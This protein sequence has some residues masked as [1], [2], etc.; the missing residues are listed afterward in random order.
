[1]PLK[2]RWISEFHGPSPYALSS[3]VVARI[4][5]DESTKLDVINIAKTVGE[6]FPEW[7]N[8]LDAWIL[9][10]Q[11]YPASQ[12]LAEI[13]VHCAF[14]LLNELR[15]CLHDRGTIEQ[16]NDVLV[17][18]GFHDP[19]ISREALNWAFRCTQYM[20]SQPSTSKELHDQR[21][22]IS[23]TCKRVH[24]DYQAQILMQ[25]A[26][27]MDMP[28]LRYLNGTK[29]WQFGW[30][31]RSE[32]F[33]ESSSTRD[34]MAGYMWS[35]NKISSKAVMRA[36]GLPI[37]LHQKVSHEKELLEAVSKISYPCVIKPLTL[38]GGKGVTANIR[39]EQELL[40][41]Y[42]I[43][44][45]FTNDALM[46]ERHIEGADHRLLMIDGKL[47]AAIR[48][49]PS[50]VVGNGALTI[51]ELIDK[52]NQGRSN[53]M[54]KSGYLRPISVDH[55][56]RQQLISQGVELT[57]V[58]EQGRSIRLR[59]NA[60]LSTGG[61]CTDVTALVHPQVKWMAEQLAASLGV[62]ILGIDY[63]SLN[64]SQSPQETGGAFIETNL[65]PGLDACV[66]A[67]WSE[68]EIGR[69]VL[70]DQLG[71]IDV[72]LKVV[73]AVENFD[74]K[75]L[76]HACPNP[77]TPDEAWVCCDIYRYGEVSLKDPQDGPWSAVRAALKNKKIKRLH[78]VCRS[79]DI[80]RDG[81]PVDRFAHADLTQ[82]NLPPSW[83]QL[84][85]NLTCGEQAGLEICI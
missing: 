33:I 37:A 16:E 45:S 27:T 63:L 61:L 59:S 66:A 43:A 57:D 42:V 23:L 50:C 78:I 5:V 17:W 82:A 12:A 52:L 26:K 14:S 28:F 6:N 31:N 8:D 19:I 9:D 10:L 75:V 35:R 73:D 80:L 64:I 70:G 69:L 2:L 21:Q 44:R 56:L 58:L 55:V 71:R 47:I 54:R 83:H 53:N 65:T 39:H 46:L 7:F 25:A 34:G 20:S 81:L 79:E 74:Q 76:S 51:Q 15:G 72:S 1:M 11:Q 68:S 48:R 3:V 13:A 36:L 84:I 29:Y 40:Q 60:N 49:E 85:I 62:A 22:K 77:L 30:G 18:L 32:V 4:D 38:G 24:P 41:A 67:G